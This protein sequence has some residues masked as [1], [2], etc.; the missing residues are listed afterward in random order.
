MK[1]LKFFVKEI[2]LLYD[3]IKNYITIKEFFGKYGID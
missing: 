2:N 1:Q 3:I